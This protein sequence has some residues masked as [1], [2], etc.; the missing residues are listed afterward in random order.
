MRK[1]PEEQ[2]AALEKQRSQIEARLKA[3]AAREASAERKADTRRKVVVGALVLGAA[4]V[5]AS[6]RQWLITILKNAPRRPADAAVLDDV[7]A[8]LT[9]PQ[10]D[11]MP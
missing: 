7:V 8:T 10:Q 9:S 4:E 11:M 6:H 5:S 1:S 3:I 2:R